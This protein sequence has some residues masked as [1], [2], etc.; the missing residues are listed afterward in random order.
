M[1]FGSAW[2]S[3]L[4]EPLKLLIYREVCSW[5]SQAFEA[6]RALSKYHDLPT[7]D[8]NSP[9]MLWS[10]GD[11]KMACRSTCKAVVS[12]WKTTCLL[13][14]QLASVLH[15]KKHEK[16]AAR[17]M[18][19]RAQTELRCIFPKFLQG[20]P[21]A[22][23]RAVQCQVDTKKMPRKGKAAK[24]RYPWLRNQSTVGENPTND[25]A[26]RSRLGQEADNV[27]NH[28][29]SYEILYK[30][31][32]IIESIRLKIETREKPCPNLWIT[33]CLCIPTTLVSRIFL[34]PGRRS[35]QRHPPAN[36]H[37]TRASWSSAISS[38][39]CT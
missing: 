16:L 30:R 20:S 22:Y 3:H 8:P 38:F 27:E 29:N 23:N 19:K 24:A 1:N 13:S 18:I 14:T 9:G 36:S 11:D 37:A 17:G 35:H 32:W 4:F 12:S 7:A 6:H 2:Q 39:Q 28:G 33:A 5:C 21:Q 25:D 15:K 10:L 26:P 31:H 34:V